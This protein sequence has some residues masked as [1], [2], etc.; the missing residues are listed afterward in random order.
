MP[1]LGRRFLAIATVAAVVSVVG[2]A[3]SLWST[4]QSVTTLAASSSA[5]SLEFMTGPELPGASVGTSYAVGLVTSGGTGSQTF[6]LTA[7]SVPAGLALHPLTGVVSGT[8]TQEGTTTFT[9][10]ATDADVEV[11]AAARDFSITV[12][13]SQRACHDLPV[14]IMG[15]PGDDVLTGTPGSDVFVGLDGNDTIIGADGSDS[16]CGGPGADTEIGGAG[17]DHLQGHGGT[18][19][20][21]GGA[22]NDFLRGG[23]DADDLVGA[24]G[25]DDCG[26]GAGADRATECEVVIGVP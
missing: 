16:M 18:D 26:G 2:V 11:T 25:H 3:G 6:A 15:T 13:E 23:P 5:G 21:I 17:D 1:V 9:V 7:G 20:L 22:G 14:T 12:G 10:T 19:R 8:P 24:S 4:A